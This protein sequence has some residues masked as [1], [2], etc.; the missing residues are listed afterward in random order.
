MM[1]SKD[2]QLLADAL[3]HTFFLWGET[4]Q[5]IDAFWIAAE[6]VAKACEASNPRFNKTRFHDA[7]LISASKFSTPANLYWDS[8]PA[9][10]SQT[11]SYTGRVRP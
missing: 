6:S 9:I 10:E 8:I 5:E 4:P 3:G 2:F 11:P 1:T 7:I